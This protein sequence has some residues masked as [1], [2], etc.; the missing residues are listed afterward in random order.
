MRGVEGWTERDG[1]W[2][3]AG[4]AVRRNNCFTR[5]KAAAPAVS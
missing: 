2:P 4:T 3:E 1:K 5:V